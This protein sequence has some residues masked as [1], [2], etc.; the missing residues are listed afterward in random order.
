MLAG[1]ELELPQPVRKSAPEE[2]RAVVKSGTHSRAILT[3]ER[4]GLKRFRMVFVIAAR[5]YYD[6]T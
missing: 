4:A 1:E 3:K 2:H 5:E 6:Q